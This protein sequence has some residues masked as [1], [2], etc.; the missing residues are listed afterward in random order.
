MSGLAGCS[1]AAAWPT[2]NPA[3]HREKAACVSRAL[4]RGSAVDST[5]APISASDEPPVSASGGAPAASSA[6]EA[7][8]PL[9]PHVRRSLGA[10]R[11]QACRP[12][13]GSGEAADAATDRRRRV[14]GPRG[15]GSGGRRRSGSIWWV[16]PVCF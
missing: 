1:G 16:E 15:S 13:H 5:T 2:G 4:A 8:G 3:A 12:G 11:R 9:G 6:S 7:Q 10:A 14:A